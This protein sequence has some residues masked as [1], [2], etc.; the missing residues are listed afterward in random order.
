M[1]VIGGDES[2]F[3][4]GIKPKCMESAACTMALSATSGSHPSMPHCS[5]STMTGTLWYPIMQPV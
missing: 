3:G 2:Q 4:V 5:A 1:L